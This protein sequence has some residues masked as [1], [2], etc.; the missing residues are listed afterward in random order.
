MPSHYTR[1]S[2]R[3]N[4]NNP[5]VIVAGGHALFVAS[6]SIVTFPGK[7]PG[8]AS[9]MNILEVTVTVSPGNREATVPLFG[10]HNTIPP[11]V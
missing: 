9:P 6:A 1:S 5:F 8:I 2:K 10:P 4:K 3:S 11:V 7:I